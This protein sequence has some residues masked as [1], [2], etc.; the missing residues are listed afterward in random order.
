M[1]TVVP[2]LAI[3]MALLGAACTCMATTFSTP[4]E[5]SRYRTAEGVEVITGRASALPSTA[6]GPGT[7]AAATPAAKMRDASQV[8][9][10][11]PVSTPVAKPAPIPADEQASRDKDRV[12][13]LTSELINEGKALEKKRS[14]LRSPKVD[15][16]LSTEQQQALREEIAR[17]EANV[18]ALNAELRR[19]GSQTRVELAN[20]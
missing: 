12:N 2:G 7:P 1:K 13:I 18:K 11:H 10:L 15:A 5:A 16:E 19:A 17:H 9:M 14:A 20:Q 4:I 8:P 6:P 3:G